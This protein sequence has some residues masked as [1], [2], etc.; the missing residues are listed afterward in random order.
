M[1]ILGKKACSFCNLKKKPN[2][3]FLNEPSFHLTIVYS[4]VEDDSADW[5]IDEPGGGAPV[6]QSTSHRHTVPKILI[7][8]QPTTIVSINFKMV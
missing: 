7:I 5:N 6:S 2:F 8:S 1:T 3:I 4:R